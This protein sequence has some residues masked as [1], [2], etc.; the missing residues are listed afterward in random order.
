MR[1]LTKLSLAVL[2]ATLLTWNVAAADEFEL[3]GYKQGMTLEQARQ[4]AVSQNQRL[5]PVQ[6]SDAPSR[7][8]YGVLGS[9]DD[10]NNLATLS[11]C[12]DRLSRASYVLSGG[13]RIFVSLVEK[14]KA[15]YGYKVL[16]MDTDRFSGDDDVLHYQLTAYLTREGDSYHVEIILTDSELADAKE[17][18]IIFTES[19]SGCN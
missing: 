13:M 17:T 16:H 5:K 8:A 4:I 7:V 6:L 10:A 9:A 15:S 12:H 18:Q 11:F 2:T 1:T 14:Y 3:Y 19:L